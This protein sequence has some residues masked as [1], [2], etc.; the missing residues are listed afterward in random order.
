MPNR[1][2]PSP[3]S[4]ADGVDDSSDPALVQRA[5]A[6]DAAAFELIMRRHNRRLFRAARGIVDDSAEAQ[7]VV[8]EA[9]LRAFTRLSSYRA[10]SALGTWLT[11]IAVN[12]ALDAVRARGRIVLLEA[13]PDEGS[14]AM[15][16]DENTP[17]APGAPG[18][19]PAPDAP[20]ALAERGQLRALLEAA[21]GRLPPLYRTVFMLRAV[22]ELSVDETARCLGVSADVVKTRYLR[23]RSLLRDTLGAQIEAHTTES[24]AF[25]GPRCDAVVGNVLAAL[26]T[27][28]LVRGT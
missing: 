24:F 12:A 18:A 4:R 11:R 15:H 27:R 7:D 10:E 13:R 25:A 26:R 8:Q 17:E 1:P 9:Y 20:D 19:L 23:A 28:G 2:T 14:E 6:G 3:S 16:H 5:C 22:E 21:I